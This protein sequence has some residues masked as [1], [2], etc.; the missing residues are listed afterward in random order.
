MASANDRFSG[1][2]GE[3]GNVITGQWERRGEDGS[4]A[5]WMDVTLTRRD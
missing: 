4:W 2:F 3:S 1:A 5:A